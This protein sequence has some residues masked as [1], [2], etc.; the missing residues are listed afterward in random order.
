MT[1]RVRRIDHVGVAVDD[2]E[3]AILAYASLGLSVTHDELL[4][5][6]GVRLVYL[7]P[8]HTTIGMEASTVQLV[9]PVGPGAVHEWMLEHGEGIHHICFA[10]D[11][12]IAY[13]EST[14]ADGAAVF[15]GGRGRRA[16]FMRGTTHGAIIELTESEPFADYIPC[17]CSGRSWTGPHD[18][19][20]DTTGSSGPAWA[21]GA[22]MP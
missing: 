1:P 20:R 5:D 12:V 16:C 3:A 11:D 19:K 17:Q 7:S 8:D 9:Q 2:A 22:V 4:P 6:V 15:R 14:G 18:S 10:I 13:L 21:A